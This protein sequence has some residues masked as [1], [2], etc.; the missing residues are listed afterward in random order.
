MA[1]V[2]LSWTNPSDL[3]DI[4]SIKVYRK[5]GNHTS[6]DKDTFL[7]SGTTLIDTVAVGSLT[8]SG[9]GSATDS[10]AA[11]SETYTYGAFSYNAGGHGP[12]DLTDSVVST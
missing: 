1:T 5:Q 10:T 7:G 11:S 3:S 12:G 9:S 2:N 8:A 4:D 6:E